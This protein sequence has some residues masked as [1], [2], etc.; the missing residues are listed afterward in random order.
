MRAE[1]GPCPQRRRFIGICA[2]LTVRGLIA[3]A[4]HAH[5]AARGRAMKPVIWRGRAMGAD[6]VI[7]LY[8]PQIS[9]AEALMADARALIASLEGQ[10]S[11]YQD[12]SALSRLNRDGVLTA[13][14]PALLDVLRLA[15]DM[16]GA[17]Q[18][19]FDITVQPLWKLYRDHFARD[20]ADPSGPSPGQIAAARASVDARAINIQSDGRN[21][22]VRFAKPGMA[23]TLN[24]IAQGYITD[25]VAAL[26]RRAGMRHVLLDLGEFRALGPHP[27]GRA[28]RI[29]LRD[30]L[31]PGRV[32]T[33]TVLQ[34]GALA[35]SGGYGA[36][37]DIDGRFHHLFDPA[38]GLP[39]QHYRSLSIQGPDAARADAL[40]TGLSALPLADAKAAL[41]ALGPEWRGYFVTR[42]GAIARHHWPV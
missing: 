25:Q 15:S 38:S 21:E 41:H 11:L 16:H 7:T 42:N 26:L 5:D 8:H 28:W 39:A 34:S 17:T 36:V 37:F 20:D 40:S 12:D 13:A 33:Q 27:E 10:L 4:A 3:P 31:N 1:P 19:A 6:T 24:G 22:T 30:P 35:T 29:G 9:L 14:P 18:G 2:S 32:M 23:V